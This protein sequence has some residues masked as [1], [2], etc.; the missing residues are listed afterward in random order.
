ME[1]GQEADRERR[2]KDAKK[3]GEQ[4]ARETGI[5]MHARGLKPEVVAAPPTLRRRRNNAPPRRVPFSPFHP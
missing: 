4:L 1:E 5:H 3:T 2:E